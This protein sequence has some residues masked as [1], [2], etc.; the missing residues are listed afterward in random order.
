MLV[1][2]GCMPRVDGKPSD[3]MLSRIEAAI[4]EFR[5][6]DYDKVI[7]SGGANHQPIPEAELM[8]AVMHN[9]IPKKKI[10]LEKR[11]LDTRHNAVFVWELL[12]DKKI[13][14]ISVVTS[15]FHVRRVRHIFRKIFAHQKTRIKIVPARAKIGP[16]NR[17]IRFVRESFAILD[18]KIRGIR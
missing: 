1:V 8:A 2:L 5:K 12:K 10:I 6:G 15:D 4:K 17:L 16:V 3:I 7:L 11:S 14:S 9:R 13:S 18:L